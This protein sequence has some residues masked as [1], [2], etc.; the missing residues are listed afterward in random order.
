MAKR[1]AGSLLVEARLEQMFHRGHRRVSVRTF[2]PD[3][4]LRALTGP[5]HYQIGDAASVDLLFSAS[6][7]NGGIEPLYRVG[8][9]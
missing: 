2:D 9:R 5:Q 6:E 1:C 4:E 7:R 3:L 8:Q